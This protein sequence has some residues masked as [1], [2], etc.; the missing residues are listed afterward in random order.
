[1]ETSRKG[2]RNPPIWGKKL[3]V[4]LVIDTKQFRMLSQSSLIG[5]KFRLGHRSLT[6]LFMT[7]IIDRHQVIFTENSDFPSDVG[8]IGITFNSLCVNRLNSSLSL[9]VKRTRM[10]WESMVTLDLINAANHLAH[11]P[12]EPL[13]SKIVKIL[14]F[15]S[16]QMRG[17]M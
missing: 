16:W 4:L 5:A 1:M 3:E 12:D 14:N 6:N 8:T 11:T 17:S 9:L 7:I 10:E 13:R 15:Q 2:L